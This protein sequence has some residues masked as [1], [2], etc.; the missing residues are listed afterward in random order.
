MFRKNT[1]QQLNLDDPTINL[2]KYLRNNLEKSW[3]T[4]F[5][6][7]IFSNINEERFKVLYS[8]EVSRPNAPINVL[9][10]LFILK[11]NLN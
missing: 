10:G 5:N 7:Y 11:F 1:S 9:V 4:P 8:N 2:P 3:A 6:K